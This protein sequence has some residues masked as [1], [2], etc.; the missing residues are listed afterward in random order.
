MKFLHHPNRSEINLCAVLQALSDPV[1]L[2]AIYKLQNGNELSC[3]NLELPVVKSTVSHHLRTLRESGI[4][5]VRIQGTQR[6]M[7]LRTDDLEY[8]FPGL[9]QSILKAYESSVEYLN[10]LNSE[11]QT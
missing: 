9:L 4:I 7:S 10:L 3:S 1:R 6:F 5:H 11:Q 2:L 8:R